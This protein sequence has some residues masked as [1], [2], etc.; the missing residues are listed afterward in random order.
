V[1]MLKSCLKII[2]LSVIISCSST[3]HQPVMSS[4]VLIKVEKTYGKAAKTR[5]MDWLAL[6]DNNQNS[7][8]WYQ[9]NIVNQFFNRLPFISDMEQ[10]STTDY[11]ATPLEFIIRH[12]GDC[13]DYTIAKYN[14]LKRLGFSEN[15]LR[16]LQVQVKADGLA[17]AHMVLAYYENQTAEPLILDSIKKKI[18][19]LGA[20][21]DIEVVYSFNQEGLWLTKG[22]QR[23]ITRV[24]DGNRVSKWV[25]VV[26]RMKND[27]I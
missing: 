1:L 22:P 24:G 6:V 23:I 27:N 7:S 12:G 10:W 8:R 26:Q 2:L 17:K 11:W 25:K 3:N 20:R 19:P 15:Q 18:H 14:T 4:D 21:H 13:E 16:L 5:V 9:L